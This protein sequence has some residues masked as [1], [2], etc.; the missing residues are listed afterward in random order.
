M[1]KLEDM[2]KFSYEMA[3]A[4]SKEGSVIVYKLETGNF[5]IVCDIKEDSSSVVST[6]N[7]LVLSP[8]ELDGLEDNEYL[9]IPEGSLNEED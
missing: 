9:L 4:Y 5:A 2:D 1:F 3:K 7:G 8:E 6:E